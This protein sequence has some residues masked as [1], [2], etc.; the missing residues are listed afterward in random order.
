M[1]FWRTDKLAADIKANVLS[2]VSKKNYFIGWSVIT[3][4]AMTLFAIGGTDN[5]QAHLV[6]GLL[7]ILITILG[8]NATFKTNGGHDYI[9]R[10]VALSFTLQIKFF[11]V[12]LLGGLIFGIASFIFKHESIY[13]SPWLDVLISIG[14]QIAI[15]WRLNVHLKNIN[16]QAQETEITA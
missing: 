16:A 10:M 15:F 2:D 6:E 3:S 4:L 7:T 1:Y 14:M 13:L 12:G 8:I 9:A 11:V 5:V